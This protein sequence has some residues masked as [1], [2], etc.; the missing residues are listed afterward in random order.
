MLFTQTFFVVSCIKD[1]FAP[2]VIFMFFVICCL[3][4]GTKGEQFDIKS[5]NVAEAKG[6][7]PC[8]MVFDVLLYNDRVLTNLPL[9]ERLTYL[10]KVVTPVEGRIQLSEHKEAHSK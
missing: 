7:Q 10:D 5:P 2:S 3:T 6:Y 8:V 4:T 1:F 9:R